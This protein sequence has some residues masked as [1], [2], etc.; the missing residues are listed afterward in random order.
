MWLF[1]NILI[2][3]KSNTQVEYV[4]GNLYQRWTYIT[5]NLEIRFDSRERQILNFLY[6]LVKITQQFFVY[7]TSFVMHTHTTLE[8]LVI[9]ETHI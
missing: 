8:T 3:W 9:C 4:V 7:I 1:V 5:Y 6:K 2:L